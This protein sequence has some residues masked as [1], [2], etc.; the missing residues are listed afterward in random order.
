MDKKNEKPCKEECKNL[1]RLMLI[2]T[3]TIVTAA[4]VYMIIKEGQRIK[5]ENE[6]L[7]YEVW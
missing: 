5:E 2:T 6:L 4:A 7:S 3:A 1:K